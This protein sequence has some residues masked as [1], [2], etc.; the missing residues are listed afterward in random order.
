MDMEI[1]AFV[2][3]DYGL[4]LPVRK[5]FTWATDVISYGLT[6]QRNQLWSRPRR[7]W[8]INYAGLKTAARDKLDELFGRAAGRYRLFNILDRHDYACGLTDWS[9]TAAGGE[10][11][12]QLAKDY[13]GSETETWQENKI[14][15]VPGT[16]YAPTVKLDAATFTEG[17]EYT[18]DDT[19]GII[20]FAS[21]SAPNGALSAGE[22]VTADYR[23]FFKVRFLSDT[24]LDN[25]IR[26]QTDLARPSFKLLEITKL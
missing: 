17:T 7:L 20:D 5:E 2:A 21:G 12:V 6:E 18:L 13:Y 26:T 22:V 19:T 14:A 15:I 8:H 23:F 25:L 11:T 9:Y 24:H 10:T 1:E 16:T 3:P 4:T